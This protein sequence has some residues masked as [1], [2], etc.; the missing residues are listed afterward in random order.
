[1]ETLD[2]RLAAVVE[3][4]AFVGDWTDRYRLLVQWGEEAEALA[5]DERRPEDEVSGCSSP[6]WL[7]VR[8]VAEVIE[9]RGYSPGILPQA[10]VALVVRLVDGLPQAVGTAG[11]ILDRLELRRHLSPTRALVLERMLTRVLSGV[12]GA[13]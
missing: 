2:D 10:L 9:V 11:E 7:R 12:G 8:R 3:E 1:M 5:E 13:P 6:L 4:L